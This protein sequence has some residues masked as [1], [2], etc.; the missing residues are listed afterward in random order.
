MSYN[1]G[2]KAWYNDEMKRLLD[3]NTMYV[4]PQLGLDSPSAQSSMG[5]QLP[6][7]GEDSDTPSSLSVGDN[8]SEVLPRDKGLQQ[9]PAREVKHKPLN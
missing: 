5:A 2:T 4:Q 6:D 9:W 8:D 1:N 7:A 3:N